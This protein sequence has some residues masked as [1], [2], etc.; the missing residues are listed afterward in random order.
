[1]FISAKAFFKDNTANNKVLIK[2]VETAIPVEWLKLFR[3]NVVNITPIETA[4][5]RRSIITQALGNRGRVGW[6]SAYAGAHEKGSHRGSKQ[7]ENYSRAGTGA[8]FAKR[9]FRLTQEQMPS[10]LKQLGLIK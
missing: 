4:A 1:M 3:A 10:K 7:Y 5:L 6:R 8:G 2:Q 9:A